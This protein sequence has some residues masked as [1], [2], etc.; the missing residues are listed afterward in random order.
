MEKATK[1]SPVKSARLSLLLAT[2]LGHPLSGG[3]RLE[4]IKNLGC[5]HLP[6]KF[7]LLAVAEPGGCS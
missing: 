7:L 4:P 1:G 3:E 2:P 5:W 6:H